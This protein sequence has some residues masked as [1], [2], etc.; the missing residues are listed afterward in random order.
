MSRHDDLAGQLHVETASDREAAAIAA[1]LAEYL[2]GDDDGEDSGETWD[3]KRFEFAG[4]IRAVTGVSRR[5]PRNA[6]TDDWTAAG[7]TDR[8]QR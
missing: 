3:G 5:V 1:V 8:F 4:R 6:P 7:R 2:D